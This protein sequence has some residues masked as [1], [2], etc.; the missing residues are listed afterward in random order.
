MLKPVHLVTTARIALLVGS[1]TVT[2][3]TLGPFQGAEQIFGLSDKAAHALAFGGLMA[4]AFLAF[5]RMRRADLTIAALVLGAAVEV[6]QLFDHRSASVLDWLA[7]AAGILAV[8]G[9]SMIETVR[10]MAREHGDLTLAQ[11]AELDQ[12]RRKRR[13]A[14]TF[15]PASSTTNG[16][17]SF[18]ERAAR[19]FPIK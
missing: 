2:V 10:G 4:I 7:D 1:L 16:A 5:P 12:R 3:L 13:R 9:A 19:R 14:T 17:S 18:A 15:E 11:I 6:A 8:Y